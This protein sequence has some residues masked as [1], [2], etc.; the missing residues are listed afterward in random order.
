M[1]IMFVCS[2]VNGGICHYT[3]SLA[4]SLSHSGND[5]SVLMANAPAYELASLPHRH[6]PLPLL[7]SSMTKWERLINPVLNQRTLLAQ[8]NGVDIVHYQWTNGP[9]ND[10]LQ[11]NALLRAGKRIV[12]TAHNV[13][14]HESDPQAERHAHWLYARANAIIVHGQTLQHQLLRFAPD[15]K[16]KVHV[17]PLGNY[18]FLHDLYPLWDRAK[19]RESLGW[20]EEERVV[21]FFGLIRPYKGLDTL[22]DACGILKAKDP[23]TGKKLRLLIAG[24]NIQ[25]FWE[26]ERYAELLDRAKLTAQTHVTLQHITMEEIGRYFH[27]ADIVAMPYKSGSQSA[28]LTTAYAFSKPVVVT[29][30]GSIPEVVEAGKTGIIVPPDE[31]EAFAAA[32]ERLICTPE[33]AEAMGQQGRQYAESALNWNTIAAQTERLYASLA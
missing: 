2:L 28:V 11:W 29:D 32:L 31:P 17:I 18:N 1:K 22:I 16:S 33:I 7:R 19:A 9:R 6:R 10:P 21:L 20:G 14:P 27:A 26:R 24:A 3:Y 15:T 4:D 25:N 8:A 5:V 30:V 12:Y 23:S 13:V